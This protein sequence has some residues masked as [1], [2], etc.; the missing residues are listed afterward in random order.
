[1]DSVYVHIP[2]CLAK[3]CLYCDFVSMPYSPPVAQR[4]LGALSREIALLKEAGD[5]LAGPQDKLA[6]KS[7]FI[8]G[9][10]PTVLETRQL[11]ELL[12]LLGKNFVF[13]QGSGVG[14]G[15]GAEVTIEVNPATIDT[16]KSSTLLKGGV[17]RISIGVQSFSGPELKTLGR[18]HT[19]R[20]ALD[21]VKTVKDAGFENISIDLIYGIPGQRVEDW[22]RT[23]ETALALGVRHVSAYELTLE[24][25]TPLSGLVEKGALRMPEEDEVVRLYFLAEEMLKAAGFVHYEVSNYALAGRESLHNLNYWRRGEYLGL[26]AAAHSFKRASQRFF[27]TEGAPRN[28]KRW[29]NA[30]GIFR[31]MDLLEKDVLP[32]EEIFLLTPEEEKRE[33]VFLGLRT[34]EGISVSDGRDLFGPDMEKEAG[35]L[36]KEGLLEM[37]RGFI[38]ASRAGF[39]VLDAIILRL[40]AGLGL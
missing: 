8:G 30:D 6:V 23:L 11:E 10:T 38:R 19:S 34:R 18:L 5:F 21:A 13:Q 3:K 9:G 22:R 20:D 28:G 4:Y 7:L 17:N 25:H 16:E 2:F 27:S 26:G 33:F 24:E 35:L 32:A 39:P 12:D 36:V 14:A 40:L 31:Y 1:M 29:K 15:A 37:S